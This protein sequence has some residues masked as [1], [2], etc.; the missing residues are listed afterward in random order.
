MLQNVNSAAKG[1]RNIEIIFKI[2]SI[3]WVQTHLT[4]HN[5][6]QNLFFFDLTGYPLP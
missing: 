1:F 4:F 5:F 3:W 2:I 6:F